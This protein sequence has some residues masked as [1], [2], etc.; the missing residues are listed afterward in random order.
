MPPNTPKSYAP[1]V[2]NIYEDDFLEDYWNTYR[3][4]LVLFGDDLDLEYI[5]ESVWG[6]LSLNSR[7]IEGNRIC[8]SVLKSLGFFKCK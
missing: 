3:N 7:Y 2:P 5:P 4:Q 6:K 8:V 1:V